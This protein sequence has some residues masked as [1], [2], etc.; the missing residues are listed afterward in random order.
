M[1]R[2]RRRFLICPGIC[3]DVRSFAFLSL[4]IASVESLFPLA[5][6]SRVFRCYGREGERDVRESDPVSDR[7][8][9]KNSWGIPSD[10]VPI[11][12]FKIITGHLVFSFSQ[13]RSP[14]FFTHPEPRNWLNYRRDTR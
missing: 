14:I 12:I 11:F 3:L 6:C 4:K 2:V 10:L 5:I 13:S 9:L 8:F 7:N 1:R